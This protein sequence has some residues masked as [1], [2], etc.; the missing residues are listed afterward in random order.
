[1]LVHCDLV[2]AHTNTVLGLVESVVGLVPGGGGVKETY[3]R[4]YQHTGDWQK[5]ARNTFNQV[6]Y[7]QTASSPDEASPLMYFL[8]ERDRQ[9]MNRDR[10]IEGARAAL[11]DLSRDYKVRAKPEFQLAGGEAFSGMVEFLEKG[12]SKGMFFPHDLTVGTAVADIVTGGAN[13]E[14]ISVSEEAMFARERASF[15][16]LAKTENTLK[17]IKHLLRNGEALRN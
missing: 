7:G 2:V 8:P 11:V 4:W 10:L 9:V 6:G 13:S 3:W 15:I 14:K 16:T 1:M 12:V 17:R 5:A